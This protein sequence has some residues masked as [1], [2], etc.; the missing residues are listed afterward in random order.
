M[1]LALAMASA[2]L[3]AACA[4]ASPAAPL[5]LHCRHALAMAPAAS[6]LPPSITNQLRT[7]MAL[8][9]ERWN[10]TDSIS[11]GEL[12]ASY[13]WAARAGQT[14]LVAYNVGGDDCCHI[15]LAAFVPQGGAASGYRQVM[16]EVGRPDE[17][18][19]ASCAGIDRFLDNHGLGR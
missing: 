1:R 12:V 6:A 15:R 9:G 3:V 19:D 11:P 14:W 16:P 10:R 8:N 17:F 7:W 4:P 2:A 13:E 5:A 18:G